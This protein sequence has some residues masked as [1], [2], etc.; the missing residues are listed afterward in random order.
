MKSIPSVP[1]GVKRM[2]IRYK[3]ISQRVLSFIST[4]GVGSTVSGV[5]YLSHYPVEYYSVYICPVFSPNFLGR[6]FSACNTI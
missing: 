2:A 3:Y 6:Y 5:T 1:G 4:E